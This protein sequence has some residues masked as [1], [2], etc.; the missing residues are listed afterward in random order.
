MTTAEFMQYVQAGGTL[1]FACAVWLE[2]REMRR[3]VHSLMIRSLPELPRAGTAP[4]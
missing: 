2:L 1:A 4:P 3:L